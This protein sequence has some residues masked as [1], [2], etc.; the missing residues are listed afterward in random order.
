M[1]K[2]IVALIIILGGVV[3]W[4]TS[5]MGSGNADS[6][7]REILYI[8]NPFVRDEKVNELLEHINSLDTRNYGEKNMGNIHGE[9]DRGIVRIEITETQR[10][11]FK[12][13]VE[14]IE[15]VLELEGLT[16]SIYNP[17]WVNE[18]KDF[19]KE[20]EANKNVGTITRYG[21]IL[22]TTSLYKRLEEDES[23]NKSI[24]IKIPREKV[25]N[26]QKADLAQALKGEGYAL[27]DLV[28]GGEEEMF[29]FINEAEM[30]RVNE[31]DILLD[32]NRQ[33]VTEIPA[34]VHY[35]ILTNQDKVSYIKGIAEGKG[36]IN[37]KEQDEEML[38][39]AAGEL[40]LDESKVIQLK[41]LLRETL[42]NPMKNRKE[43]IGEWEYQAK[44]TRVNPGMYERIY[45]EIILK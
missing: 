7:N 1:K 22:V 10:E 29:V 15:R 18:E 42:E 25:Q 32:E 41:E 30:A 45:L 39:R 6:Y 13:Q 8:E 28:V 9:R 31:W 21:D 36:N 14:K 26:P 23:F 27:K 11:R 16:E 35:E 24:I 33:V 38:L 3:A 20:L 40:G 43:K 2:I 37:F 4:L 12:E 5:L 17:K 44:Y 34:E 19:L